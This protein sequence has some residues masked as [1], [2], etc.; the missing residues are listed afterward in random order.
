MIA[1]C[2]GNF[3]GGGSDV[4]EQGELFGICRAT[5]AAISFFPARWLRHW[6]LGG[7]RPDGRRCVEMLNDANALGFPA[8][9]GI[10][11][12]TAVLED[13]RRNIGIPVFEIPT[14]PPAIT[15]LRLK[16]AF[17]NALRTL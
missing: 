2:L 11:H 14:L 8:I 10:D 15:G 3:F 9:F 17:E 6:M 16:N 12:T 5:M 13:L 4:D 1:Q 7:P